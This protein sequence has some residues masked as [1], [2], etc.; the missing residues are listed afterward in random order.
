LPTFWQV[1][2]RLEKTID[3]GNVGNLGLMLDFFNITNNNMSLGVQ[4]QANAR[5]ADQIME[6]VNPR[7]VR[8]GVRLRF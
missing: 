2:F 5:N 8:L 3:M 1:D 7:V 4:N 6:I